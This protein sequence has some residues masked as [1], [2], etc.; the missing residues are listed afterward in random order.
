MRTK[1]LCDHILVLLTKN[2]LL[3][4]MDGNICKKLVNL[5]VVVEGARPRFY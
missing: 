2:Y 5:E 4:R 3:N 1:L